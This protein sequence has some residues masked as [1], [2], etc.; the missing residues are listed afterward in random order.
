MFIS[1]RGRAADPSGGNGKVR[2]SCTS[3]TNGDILNGEL[4]KS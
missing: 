4:S 2:I 1:L 3:V